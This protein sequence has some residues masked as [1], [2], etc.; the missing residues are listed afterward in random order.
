MPYSPAHKA[1]TRSRI[2]ECARRQFNR[3]GF[4]AV[5]IDD[6]MEQAGLTRGGFYN[7][8]ASKDDLYSEAVSSYRQCKAVERWDDVELDL[9]AS[10]QTLANQ[11]VNAYLSQRHLDDLEAQ[12][13]MIALPSDTARAGPTVREA[14]QTVLEGMI[15]VFAGA[16][17]S[18][19]ESRQKALAMTILCVGG[20]VLARA[21]EDQAL[22]AEI[23]GVARTLALAVAADA[24]AGNEDDRARATQDG[25]G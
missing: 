17:S 1:K 10:A 9:S 3:Y 11:L 24:S 23:R 16:V 2:V 5:S 25:P 21:I 12:C 7:H 14:Y 4:D 6:V 20:M 19:Q 15:N 13:P 18:V 8:F 22:G